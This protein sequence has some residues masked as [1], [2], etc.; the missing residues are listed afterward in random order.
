MFVDTPC[1][2]LGY[3]DSG[4]G[5]PVVLLHANPGD[6][7]DWDGVAAALATRF[8]VLALDWPGFGESPAPAA[9]ASATWL[10]E[11]LGAFLDAVRPGAAWLIGSSVGGYAALSEALI[12]PQRVHGVVLVDP[13]GFTAHTAFTRAF[14][15]IKGR[16]WVTRRI[17]GRFARRYLRARNEITRAMIARADLERDE[18]ARVAVDAAI[19]RS[20][21]DPSC[22]LRERAASVK[23]PVRIVWG[24]FDPNVPLA[25]DGAQA[26]RA[27][28][29][30]PFEILETGHAP[31]A[32]DPDGFLRVVLPWLAH[33]EA[34]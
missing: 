27:L 9:P 5:D 2:R 13:A 24:R 29:S 18:P 33:R 12:R 7:R 31:H 11:V 6:R 20:F 26:R 19:W 8:R 3:E 30:A 4:H 21:R 1:G 17:A 14:C 16:E 15:A 28:P 25:K 22:D 34:A 10:A 32:E 23:V